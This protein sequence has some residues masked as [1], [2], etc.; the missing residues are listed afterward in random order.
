MKSILKSIL[1]LVPA[2]IISLAFVQTSTEVAMVDQSSID[3]TYNRTES[4]I[5]YLNQRGISKQ[6][7]FK[8]YY[9][10]E[11]TFNAGTLKSGEEKEIKIPF[12][13]TSDDD[14]IKITAVNEICTCLV[15]NFPEGDAGKFKPGE[16]KV[17]TVK[18]ATKGLSGKI[19][20]PIEVRTFTNRKEINYLIWIQMR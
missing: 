9:T 15:A 3:V 6:D 5:E 12:K 17:G 8:D 10:A 11:F 14:Y 20:R 18:F 2:F 1:F 16:T 13:N 7:I 4:Y 19:R